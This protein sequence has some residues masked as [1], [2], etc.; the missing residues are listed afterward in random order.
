MATTVANSSMIPEN[1]FL[2]FNSK[3]STKKKGRT[4]D[5]VKT[6]VSHDVGALRRCNPPALLKLPYTG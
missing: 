4:D 2:S 3:F 6:P 1:I 5:L